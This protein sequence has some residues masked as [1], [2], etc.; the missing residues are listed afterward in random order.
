M[1]HEATGTPDDLIEERVAA[2]ID[3][4]QQTI[5][6]LPTPA[7]LIAVMGEA[8]LHRR[9]GSEEVMHEQLMHLA[10]QGQRKHIGIQIVPASRGANAGHLGAF[11]VASL[12]DAD[13]LAQ[14]QLQRQRRPELCR[15]GQR[16]RRGP[17][18]RHHGPR[19]P[20]LHLTPR[21]F[22][23]FTARIRQNAAL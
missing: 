11:T 8:V 13:V 1:L 16:S 2:R 22:A 12:D 10:D 14:V 19:V 9:V 21:A 5:E 6:R 7:K 18:P 15:G 4:L 23:D 3:L 20:V 17:D